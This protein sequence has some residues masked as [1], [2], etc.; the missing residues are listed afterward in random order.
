MLAARGG[1]RTEIR[2]VKEASVERGASR[3]RARAGGAGRTSAARHSGGHVLP[4][5]GGRRTEIRRGKEASV[6]LGASLT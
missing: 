5:R 2:G 4:A 1:R 6:E 3:R